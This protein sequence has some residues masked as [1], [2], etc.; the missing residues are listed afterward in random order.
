M[1]AEPEFAAE[2]GGIVGHEAVGADR[3][4]LAGGEALDVVDAV[5][6]ALLVGGAVARV[7]RRV[8]DHG[9]PGADAARG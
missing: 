7:V 5:E 8:T 3:A 1:R 6:D 9:E 2:R 4:E